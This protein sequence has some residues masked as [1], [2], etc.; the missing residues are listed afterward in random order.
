M[1]IQTIASV[2]Q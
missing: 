1:H 2:N